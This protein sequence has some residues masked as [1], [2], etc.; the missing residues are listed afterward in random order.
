MIPVAEIVLTVN[1]IQLSA[2]LAEPVSGGAKA[3]ILAVPGGGYTGAYWH[4]PACLDASLLT[5]G[6]G[7]GYQVIALD[8]PGYGLS[9]YDFPDGMELNEQAGIIADLVMQLSV[10]TGLGVFLVGHSMG[11][12]LSLMASSLPHSKN[13]LGIDV[14]GVPRRFSE[15]LA[16]AMAAVFCGEDKVPPGRG[17]RAMF[18]GPRGTFN[19]VLYD[20]RDASSR[21]SPLSELSDSINWPDCFADVAA[22]IVVPVQY[23]LGEYELV[24]RC[25]WGAL[26]D[27]GL[28]FSAS[29]RVQLHRQVDA[30][31]NISLHYVGRA[32]HL[33]VLAFFD[34][35]LIHS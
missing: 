1:G 5:L 20:E 35:V 25:D 4:H 18:Y 16:A 6:A 32:Y 21:E 22:N 9:E 26:N 3:V 19:P 29:P 7:L 15:E 12:I 24:T 10:E 13:L 30:G 34:E 2:K 8:R 28:L 27:T 17:A 31:H 23:T 33:R 14:A 11:G